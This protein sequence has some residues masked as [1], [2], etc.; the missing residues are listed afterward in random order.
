MKKGYKKAVVHSK[1][2]KKAVVVVD[3][4]PKKS[5]NRKV[6]DAVIR[7]AEKKVTTYTESNFSPEIIYGS[8]ASG[9]ETSN[10][11]S[12]TPLLNEWSIAQGSAVS[13][14]V[15]NRVKIH[16]VKLRFWIVAAGYDENSNPVP[17]PC[18]V[19]IWFI[20]YKA[21]PTQLPPE[22]A[23]RGGSALF[24]DNGATNTGLVGTFQD[25]QLPVNLDEFQVLKT[26]TYKIGL[27]QYTS[28]TGA[29]S[30]S[31]FY[32][33]ND[34]KYAVL[35]TI[36][37]TKIVPAVYEFN[38]S[39]S[40]ST[41]KNVTMLIQPIWATGAGPGALRTPITMKFTVETRYTDF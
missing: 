1:N 9:L 21:A 4:K 19:K 18:F 15:G 17:T 41:S 38:D 33:N 24:L 14:R 23:I 10:M 27:Q 8:S 6:R 16:N 34:F 28:G 32:S 3:S 12:M 36:D 29:Q 25:L 35:K 37:L 2:G 39:D 7:M 22:D 11:F 20:R 31:G 30:A 13:N 5:F 40:T 26:K